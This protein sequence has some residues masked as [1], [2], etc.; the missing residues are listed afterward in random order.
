MGR[1]ND[2]VVQAEAKNAVDLSLLMNAIAGLPFCYG[3]K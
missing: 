2:T 1:N 3:L